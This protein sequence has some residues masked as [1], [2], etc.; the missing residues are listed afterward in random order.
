MAIIQITFP[1]S[2]NVSI[3]PTDILYAT[4]KSQ[5]GINSPDG[6]NKPQVVGKVIKVIHESNAIEVDT[7][8]YT[9]FKLSLD[10]Y[11][12]FSKNRSANMSGIL[13]YYALTE[14]RNHSKNKAEMFATG[15]EYAPS[16]K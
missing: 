9:V 13:G 11:L 14:Y 6:G 2:L 12:F 16:S 1:H 10:N 15:A 3:Q 4:K 7:M 8:S 5:A